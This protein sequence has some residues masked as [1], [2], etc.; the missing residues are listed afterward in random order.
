MKLG[1]IAYAEPL[2]HRHEQIDLNLS[3]GL[4]L[5]CRLPEECER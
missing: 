1:L 2:A 4:N 5:S 3:A